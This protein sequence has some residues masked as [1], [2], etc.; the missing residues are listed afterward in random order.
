MAFNQ[1][2][3]RRFQDRGQA[4]RG[5][6]PPAQGAA[7]PP[8]RKPAAG[9]QIPEPA[10]SRARRD[11]IQRPV[12]P[13]SSANAG[14]GRPTERKPPGPRRMGPPAPRM[15]PPAPGPMGEMQEEQVGAAQPSGGPPVD[16]G[17][18]ANQLSR[19]DYMAAK[20]GN[21]SAPPS[22]ANQRVAPE[23]AGLSADIPPGEGQSQGMAKPQ[24]P[25]SEGEAKANRSEYDVKLKDQ[26]GQ[27]VSVKSSEPQGNM[28]AEQVAADMP[29]TN[30]TSNMG[31]RLLG[32]DVENSD[33]TPSGR[34]FE[35]EIGPGMPCN[36]NG[37][38]GVPGT[39]NSPEDIQFNQDRFNAALEQNR[40][41]QYKA[42]LSSGSFPSGN[43]MAEGTVHHSKDIAEGIGGDGIDP[44]GMPEA[45]RKRYRA[46][47][48]RQLEEFGAYP[49]MEDPDAPTPPVRPMSFSYNPYTNKFVNPEGKES[50]LDRF[51][52][53]E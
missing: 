29:A 32:L 15:R 27:E 26:D 25:M 17:T 40:G 46:D 1:E 51:G 14:A 33:R 53:G 50:M 4:E 12:G 31:E 47:S 21:I 34:E 52:G 35:G 48:I 3:D 42:A 9:G 16:R 38:L 6:R 10:I 41:D 28:D 13:P 39:Q 5:A 18:S 19:P 30:P 20:Q 36:K 37:A 2:N 8:T 44:A 11:T 23:G 49:G 7:G 24:P 43:P 22:P 45:D